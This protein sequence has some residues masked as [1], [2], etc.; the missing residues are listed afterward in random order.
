[1][2]RS[3][4][5]RVILRSSTSSFQWEQKIV[6]Q[7]LK[8]IAINAFIAWRMNTREALLRTSETFRSLGHY[9]STLNNLQSLRHF[10]FEVSKELL[11]YANTLRDNGDEDLEPK[12]VL[13][14][15]ESTRLQTLAMRRKE[16]RLFFFN[17]DDGVKFRLAVKDHEQRQLRGVTVHCALCG[18][19]KKEKGRPRGTYKCNS[20]DVHLCT[21]TRPG[22]RKTCWT[23]WHSAKNSSHASP[24]RLWYDHLQDR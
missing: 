10:I 23:I 15:G 17:S 7:M 3:T 22:E 19:N 12:T 2:D 4:Q 18:N 21:K 20:C 9:R 8:T 6:S 24:L 14:D 11:S 1:M 16:K 5:A 13:S